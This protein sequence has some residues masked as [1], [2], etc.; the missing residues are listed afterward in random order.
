MSRTLVILLHGVGSSGSDLSPLGTAWRQV[1][2]HTDFAA[3]DAPFAFD[4]GPGHQWFSLDGV[5]ETNRPERLAAARVAF[6]R[7]LGDIVAAHGLTGRLDRV[8]L[9]GFSQGSIMAL[10]AVASGRWPVAAIVAFSGRLASPQPLTPSKAT[11][12]LLIHGAADPVILAA[13]TDR[14]AVLLRQHGLD[15]ASHIL[16]RIGHTISP[17]GMAIAGDFIAGSFATPV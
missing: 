10:D 14:A 3:P 7:M 4:H 5:T 15:V 1:L 17:E 13:E 8:A 12:M 6:D 9:V 2:P 11:R 16:P